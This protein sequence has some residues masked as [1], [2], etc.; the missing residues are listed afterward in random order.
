MRALASRIVR[1]GLTRFT[2]WAL[3]KNPT[4]HADGFFRAGDGTWAH[5][6][7]VNASPYLTR[8]FSSRIRLPFLGEVQ[9]RLHHFHRDDSD[10][11][12]H[13]HP[14]RWSASFVLT[15]SYTEER[16]SEEAREVTNIFRRFGALVQD[17][18][19]SEFRRVRWFNFITDRDY[20]AI[21]QLHGDVWTLFITGDRVQSWGYFVDGEHVDSDAYRDF[22]RN[23]KA[24]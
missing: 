20:H 10:R 8:V 7:G 4:P 18:V 13:N 17:E 22:L 1:A 14:F 12:L 11:H 16:L 19:L 23:R 5:T 3:S 2:D 15:G 9:V 21:K 24:A 6:I